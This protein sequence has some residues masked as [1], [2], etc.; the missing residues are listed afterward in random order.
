MDNSGDSISR[1][2]IIPPVEP[3]NIQT[4]ESKK[5][6]HLASLRL[7]AAGL[8]ISL[9]TIIGSLILGSKSA[10][11]IIATIALVPIFSYIYTLVN[12]SL[13]AA[14]QSESRLQ[15]LIAENADLIERS[16]E[17]QQQNAEHEE[18]ETELREALELAEI[19]KAMQE[20]ASR[21]FQSLFEGLPIGATTFDNEG[22]IFEWNQKMTEVMDVPAH[23]AILHP[24]ANAIHSED[25]PEV[26]LNILDSIFVKGEMIAFNHTFTSKDKKK[27]IALKFFPLRNKEGAILGGIGCGIDV[28]EELETQLQIAAMAELQRAVLDS[29]EYAIIW[30]NPQCEVIGMNRA[31]EEI[32]GFPA[33]ECINKKSLADFH[34]PTEIFLRNVELEAQTG[35]KIDSDIELFQYLSQ[36]PTESEWQYLKADD[37][38]V[39]VGMSISALTNSHGELTGF[40][41]VAKDITEQKANAERLKMLSM[42]AK[43]SMNSVAILDASGH[44]IFTNPAFARL[45]LFDSDSVIGKTPFEFRTSSDT[46]SE[47]LSEI[48]EI[49]RKQSS[50]RTELRLI[51]PDESEYWS[52]ITISPVKGESGF[53]THIVIIEDDITEKKQTQLLVEESESRFRD[54][55][56]A[57]G[58]YIWEVDADFR[59]TY[60]SHKIAQVLGYAPE[61]VLGHS[62]LDFVNKDQVKEVQNLIASS[63]LDREPVTNLILRTTGKWGQQ[64]WQKFNAVPFFDSQNELK[65]FRGTGLDITDQKVAEDALDA[66]NT[67][68]KNILESIND[69]FYS[70]NPFNQ[71]TYINQSALN[72]IGCQLGEIIGTDIEASHSEAHWQPLLQILNEVR[73]SGEADSIELFNAS[74]AEWY[75]YRVYPNQD[76]GVSVFFQNITDRK[77]IQKQLETQMAEIN[78]ANV[79]LEIQQYKLEEA[80]LKLL[81][82]A[83]TDGLTGLKNHKTFQEFLSDKMEMSTMTGIPIGVIL[84]DVDKFKSFN[85][86]F[87]HLAGD[88]VLKG[89]ARTLQQCITE[90]HFVAR[91][92][93]EEFVIVGV[94]LDKTDMYYLADECRIALEDQDW[95]NRQVTASFGVAM[96]NSDVPDKATLIDRAD[97]ALYAS[98]EAGRNRVTQY[99]NLKKAA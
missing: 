80:N 30:S 46:S 93:G 22:T 73:Q 43:E 48:K 10:V 12:K 6:G 99:E 52:S 26:V 9:L 49:I 28:T 60:A 40:L 98:K 7:C 55:V 39:D 81:N 15:E 51:R 58:E 67:R 36:N 14:A 11:P 35:E 34:L 21:R 82:L 62:P 76:G 77:A 66:A 63:V 89:V 4:T 59:F 18:Q 78:E 37:T 33:E 24:L 32:L 95:P 17:F 70:L 2:P 91:Y 87:G 42:V 72:T 25:N 94:G 56:E 23:F 71:F 3:E 53:C 20:H 5:V 65:G 31:A 45:T 16:A 69:S 38:V 85:D 79:Q 44:V 13:Q 29:T 64:V 88:E 68:V 74:K 27:T 41:T 96:F 1:K 75:D 47:T 90:P 83:S 19:Q 8:V 50:G 54:V 97:Q 86:D 61:D 92:G 57:A 84:M